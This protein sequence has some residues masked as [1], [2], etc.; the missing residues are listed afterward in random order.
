[1]EIYLAEVRDRVATIPDIKTNVL[2]K[3]NCVKMDRT[4][5]LKQLVST[6]TKHTEYKMNSH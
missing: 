1:M 4:R 6:Y 3:D 5:Q 2:C